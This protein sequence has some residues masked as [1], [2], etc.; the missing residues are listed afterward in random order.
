MLEIITVGLTMV[1]L[2]FAILYVLFNL[3]GLIFSRKK[4]VE[5]PSPTIRVVE[6]DEEIVAVISAVISSILGE[7]SFKIRKIKRYGEDR[8]VVW[9][10][11]GWRGVRRWRGS[12]KWS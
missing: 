5:T 7:G 3:M 10:K 4:I 1:F 12:S 6:E 2:I 9:R 8:F 11:T